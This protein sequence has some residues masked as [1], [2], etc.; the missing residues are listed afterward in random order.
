[1]DSSLSLE[2]HI[3]LTSIF[4]GIVAGFIYDLY[5]AF[6]YFFK[7]NKIIT[8]VQDFLFW[9]TI[10][11]VFFYTLLKINWGE[12]RGFIILGFFIGIIIYIITFSKYIYPMTVR[13]CGILKRIIKATL[14]LILYP[15]IYLKKK[16]SS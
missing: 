4:G 13:I 15:F 14:S 11:Y 7:P 1:M 3:F 10:T 6:R 16:S 5:K 9:V 12:I 8:Y 2:L